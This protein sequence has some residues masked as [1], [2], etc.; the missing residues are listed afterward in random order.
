[1]RA[2]D[3]LKAKFQGLPWF[4]S[5]SPAIH[6]GRICL[7]LYVKDQ[8]I[9][10]GMVLPTSFETFKVIIDKVQSVRPGIQ[11]KKKNPEPLW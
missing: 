6:E 11:P 2:A 10:R 8:G 3:H 4:I 7:M 9:P 5:V 1:M